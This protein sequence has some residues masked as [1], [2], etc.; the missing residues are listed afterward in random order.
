M[1]DVYEPR[2]DSFLL[3]DNLPLLE[4]K[5]V[6]DVGTGS[7]FLALIAAKK[8][9]SVVAVDINPN[10]VGSARVDAQKSGATV[11]FRVSDLFSNVPEK[12]DVIIFNPPYL[13]YGDEYDKNAHVWC[14][15][16]TG[17]ETIERFAREAPAHLNSGGVV[18]LAF[19]SITGEEEV[20]QILE[21]AGFSVR[22]V[23]ETKVAFEK[24]V[25]FHGRLLP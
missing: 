4:G 11:E 7:G 21:S 2:E 12:F 19:S 6:L 17:R 16:K 23:A 8:A 13:P 15:G 3:A 20:R 24:L 9:R 18:A 10:A 14:G 1:T 25:V 22:R 5:A